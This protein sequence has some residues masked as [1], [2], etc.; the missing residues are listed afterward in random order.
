MN[1]VRFESH[2]TTPVRESIKL[3]RPTLSKLYYKKAF[4]FFIIII[5]T[6]GHNY[7]YCFYLRALFH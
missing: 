4:F 7:I 2:K 6:G 1:M 3:E 5:K